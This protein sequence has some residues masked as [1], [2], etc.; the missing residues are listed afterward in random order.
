MQAPCPNSNGPN[1]YLSPFQQLQYY[2]RKS[3]WRAVYRLEIKWPGMSL[4]DM[5]VW[6]GGGVSHQNRPVDQKR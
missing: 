6:L 5:Y 1:Q 2:N 4:W 3:I